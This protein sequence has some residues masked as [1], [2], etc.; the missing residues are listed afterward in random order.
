MQPFISYLPNPSQN[1]MQFSAPIAAHQ[2]IQ[3]GL[4]KLRHRFNE[5]EEFTDV[6]ATNRKHLGVRSARDIQS[7]MPGGFKGDRQV[8]VASRGHYV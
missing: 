6:V 5:D 3:T 7:V 2:D 1:R 4:N 8:I